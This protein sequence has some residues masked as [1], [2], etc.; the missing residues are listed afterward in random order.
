LVG[1]IGPHRRWTS[2]GTTLDDVKAI[3]RTLGGTVNDV[4][5]A[6]VT[7]G[8]RTLLMN[9][10]EPVDDL[11]VRALVPVSV[12]AEDA[13]G[14]FDN[15]VSAMVADLP[16]GEA[17]PVQRLA[18][19]REQ[20][21]A[22]KHSHQTHAGEG[23][24]ALGDLAPSAALAFAERASMQVLRRAP[25]HTL[26]AVVTNVP[27]PQFPLYLAGRELLDYRPFVPIFPGMR[28]GI[29]IVSYNG[30]LAFGLT[31]DYDAVPDLDVLATGIETAMGELLALVPEAL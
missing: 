18:A 22:L 1:G 6:A 12:R 28:V 9:R 24:T 17:D 16:I 29:A 25:Q 4:V 26:N 10:G 8:L 13:R 2:V 19:V 30:R 14:R 23:V 20:M 31:A 7:G 21:A 15:R 27:G 3:R 11:V 5:V